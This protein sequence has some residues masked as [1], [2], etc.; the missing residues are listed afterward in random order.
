MTAMLQGHFSKTLPRNRFG[1]T[2][3]NAENGGIKTDK[4][5]KTTNHC[6]FSKKCV[7]L[8]AKSNFVCYNRKHWGKPLARA[9]AGPQRDGSLKNKTMMKGEK[10]P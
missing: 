6:N 5:V 2:G 10:G 8:C 7:F 9:P 3:K 4:I 1:G